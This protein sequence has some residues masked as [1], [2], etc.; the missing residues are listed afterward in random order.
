MKGEKRES[1]VVGKDWTVLRKLI[2]KVEFGVEN[3][4]WVALIDGV[5]DARAWQTVI[6]AASSCRDEE[7]TTKLTDAFRPSTNAY[8]QR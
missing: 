7:F 3:V 4:W 5:I 8:R 6:Q 1:L 2:V